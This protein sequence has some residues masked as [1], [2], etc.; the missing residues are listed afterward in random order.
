MCIRDRGANVE[1]DVRLVGN[2][3]VGFARAQ[4]RRRDRDPRHRVRI[5][6]DASELGQRRVETHGVEQALAQR[7]VFDAGLDEGPPQLAQLNTGLDASKPLQHLSREHRRALR[8]C[9]LYTSRCV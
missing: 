3:V 2:H 4:H 6:R 8:T 5:A 7:G 1:V 9:L